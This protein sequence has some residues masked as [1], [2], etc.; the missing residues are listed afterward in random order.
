MLHNL[1]DATQDK[2]ISNA[3]CLEGFMRNDARCMLG[4]VLDY[5]LS[6]LERHSQ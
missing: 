4:D 3:S 1:I 6:A 5:G 2:E